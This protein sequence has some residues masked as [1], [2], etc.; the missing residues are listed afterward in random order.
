MLLAFLVDQI[1]SWSYN[2]VLIVYI[3]DRTGSPTW[4]A[5][6]T[7]AGWVPR[8]IFSTYAGVLADRFERA[9]LLFV[10][11]LLSFVVIVG[12]TAVVAV[13]GP[14]VLCLALSVVA[15]SFGTLYRPAAGG[16]VPDLLEERDLAAGN[17][18]VGLLDNLVVVLGPAIGG[19][20]LLGGEPVWGVGL[21]AL[22]YLVAA[23]LVSRMRVRS[24]GAA[25]QLG[26]SLLA[27][28]GA[29]FRVLRSRP[30]AVM[31]VGFC[32]LGTAV[33]GASTV[34]YVPIS[35]S[36]G[37]G[38]D[39]YSY[40]LAG[41]A[42]GGVLGALAVNRLTSSSR[43]AGVLVGAALVC[44]LPFV[45]TVWAG[46]P[47]AAVLLQ[48]VSGVG[49]VVLDVVA[50]TG[51]QR[52]LPSALLS[53]VLGILESA[54][55]GAALVASFGI[56]A[57]LRATDLDTSLLVM[58]L[59][60]SALAIAALPKLLR[61]DREAAA[62]VARLAPRVAVLEVLDLFATSPRPVLERLAAA[63]EPVAVPAGHVVVAEGQPSDAL[64]VLVVGTVEVTAQG[65]GAEA[66]RL[67]EMAA[68]AYFGEIGLLRGLART[69]TVR[70]VEPAELWRIPAAEFL[71]A[72]QSARLSTGTL[73]RSASW[74][75]TTHPG[76]AAGLE[77]DEPATVPR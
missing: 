66:R 75:A 76:L 7:A 52:D 26:E 29:G 22:T 46:T 51:L 68:P 49:M 4:V 53:R 32:A 9:R 25:G 44:A 21:N 55:L 18:L 40:L 61:A 15:A 39:G 60:F 12:L 10:C 72:L 27:Q 30:S 74:L 73:A 19:L 28:V 13:D 54:A 45:G 20:V 23:A 56:A 77:G 34:L 69:A 17:G 6:T 50:V 14:V 36:V 57:L 3:Y 35:K 70:T 33:Y 8:M 63:A 58:G 11:A 67:R 47:M 64:W 37:T 5:L 24:R 59:G 38:S 16:M 43:L 31:A 65:E 71:S 42:L 48:L 2:V 1:G 41:S 62:L